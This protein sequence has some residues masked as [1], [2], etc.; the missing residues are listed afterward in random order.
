ML[1]NFLFQNLIFLLNCRSRDCCFNLTLTMSLFQY[2]GSFASFFKVRYLQ[3]KAVVDNAIFRLH[4][5]FTTAFFFA[6]CVLITAFDLFGKPI[7]CISDT[8]FRG[9]SNILN[10]FCWINHTFTVP[11]APEQ[12]IGDDVAYPGVGPG[13]SL[14]YDERVVHSYY[15]WVPFVL[16]LQG[17]LFYLPHWFWK[18]F[19]DGKIRK[20]TEG[21]RGV[22]LRS[23]EECK[24]HCNVLASYLEKTLRTSGCLAFVY[25]VCELLN[26]VNAVGNIFFIDFFLGG[27]FFTYGLRVFHLIDMDQVQ[28]ND[29]MIQIFPRMTKCTFYKF[30]YSGTVETH[31]ALCLLSVNIF[32]E[33]IYIFAWFWLIVLS[34]LS[35]LVICYRLVMIASP[36]V[37]L[38]VMQRQAPT[39]ERDTAADIVHSVHFGDYFV[40]HQLGKNLDGFIFKE[41]LDDMVQRVSS[42]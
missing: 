41:L 27:A 33:K 21:Y 34:A 14:V 4:Y 2:L 23:N 7:E 19:E 18:Q 39:I 31:D 35:V 1:I 22:N 24:R 29:P 13:E 26:A 20:L 11:M 38:F 28:R 40:L 12:L 10:T 42:E 6:A 37:R 30:G 32:N 15:Q 25:V 16:F 9:G 17:M 8:A 5:R 36:F 3:D